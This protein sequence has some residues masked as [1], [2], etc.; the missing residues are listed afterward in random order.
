MAAGSNGTS[1]LFLRWNADDDSWI[2]SYNPGCD[3]SHQSD[4]WHFAVGV[5]DLRNG[6]GLKLKAG[7]HSTIKIQGE[8]SFNHLIS[9]LMESSLKPNEQKWVNEFA[10]PSCFHYVE[11]KVKE[12]GGRD[13]DISLNMKYT[14]MLRVGVQ[15][16]IDLEACPG[17]WADPEEYT[18]YGFGIEVTAGV[19][20]KI[21]VSAGYRTDWD[22]H[23]LSGGVKFRAAVCVPHYGITGELEVKAEFHGRRHALRQLTQSTRERRIYEADREFGWDV[24]QFCINKRPGRCPNCGPNTVKHFYWK[25]NGWCDLCD[26][27]LKPTVIPTGHSYDYYRCVE[28]N[29]FDICCDCYNDKQYYLMD[30]DQLRR[31]WRK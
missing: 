13:I 15:A 20:L 6:I 29:R 18:M 11:N 16:G 19:G 28:C 9:Q 25:R 23:N 3:I 7:G 30:A 1:I 12:A 26:R 31:A 8:G 22:S 10:E 4:T 27:D 24:S 17:C 5:P 2:P 14:A 21:M